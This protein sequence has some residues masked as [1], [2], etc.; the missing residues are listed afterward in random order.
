VRGA[1]RFGMSFELVA[2][3][4]SP[5]ITTCSPA[6]KAAHPPSGGGQEGIE[7]DQDRHKGPPRRAAIT[8]LSKRID[9]VVLSCCRRSRSSPAGALM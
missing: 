7:C 1:T 2:S 5:P 3:R 4:S 9:R 6:R 8:R